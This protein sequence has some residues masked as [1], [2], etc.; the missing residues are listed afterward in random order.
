MYTNRLVG[1]FLV[2]MTGL[3]FA[4]SPDSQVVLERLSSDASQATQRTMQGKAAPAAAIRSS[5]ETQNG[6]ASGFVEQDLTGFDVTL[7]DFATTVSM[8]VQANRIDVATNGRAI[9]WPSETVEA[10]EFVELT[11]LH[12]DAVIS[13]GRV[14]RLLM[15][16]ADRIR[17]V[18]GPIALMGENIEYKT[19]DV[20]EHWLTPES[21]EAALESSD[22]VRVM[23][24]PDGSAIL[25]FYRAGS[26]STILYA[27]PRGQASD[28][29]PWT[30]PFEEG[31]VASEGGG[32][33]KQMHDQVCARL[34]DTCTTHPDPNVWIPACG[35]WLEGCDVAAAR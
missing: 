14:P 27:E 21:V 20:I 22:G 25:V 5:L 2:G 15:T 35:A 9:R 17:L 11:N 16:E 32:L 23:T 30:V 3:A 10:T 8:R 4:Q 7:G 12:G 6:P 26:M 1:I 19:P 18:L 34:F 33:A 28:S 13:L 31:G 29:V 24:F